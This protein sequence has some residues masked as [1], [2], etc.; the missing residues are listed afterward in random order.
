MMKYKTSQDYEL[1]WNLAQSHFVICLVDYRRDPQIQDVAKTRSANGLIEVSAR[2]IS[3]IWAES[4]EDFIS[5]CFN[6]NL[7]WL[8]F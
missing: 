8:T 6:C 1:L 4:K 3:Y 2:G 5:Q 7:K